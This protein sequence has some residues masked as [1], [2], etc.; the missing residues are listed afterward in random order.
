MTTPD[1][2]HEKTLLKKILASLR[3]ARGPDARGE[4]VCWCP[5]HPDGKGKPPHQPNLFVSERGFYCHACGAKGSLV[6]LAEKLGVQTKAAGNDPEAIYDYCDENGTL[7]FQVIRFRGKRFRQRRPDGKDGWIWDLK[8]V[9][10]V[11][12]R[13]PELFT[14]PPDETVYIVEGEKDCDRLAA[15]GLI[16]TTNPGGAGKWRREYSEPSRGRAVAILSDNDEPGRGHVQSVAHMLHG[17]AKSIK[18]IDLPG[19]PEKGDVSDWLA[20][21][22]TIEELKHL[23]DAA[24]NWGPTSSQVSAPIAIER[25]GS[26]KSSWPD[27][28]A[29]AAFHGLAGDFVRAIEPHT[30]ADPVALLLSFLVALGNVVERAAH[31]IADGAKHYTNLFCVLVGTTSKSRKGTSWAQTLRPFQVVDEEWARDRVQHGLSSGEGLIWGVRDQIERLEPIRDKKRIVD[32]QTVIE[33]QGVEDKRLLVA[34]TEFAMT[35]RVMG[36]DGNTL[37]AIVRNA[38]DTGNLRVLT[39]NQ[40]A[41]STGAHVSIIGHI[42]K[43][44]C[45]RYFDRTEVANG[46]GNRFI[47]ACV[48]RSKLLPEGGRIH[49]VDFGPLVQRLSAAKE[50]ACATSEMTRDETARSLWYGVYPVLAEGQPGLLGAILA[51]AEAQVMRLACVYALLDLSQTVRCEHL[52]AALAVWKYCEDSARFIFGDALGDPLADEILRILRGMEGGMTR[53]EISNCFGRNREAREITRALERL[54]EHGLARCE[55]EGGA[56]GRPIERWFPANGARFKTSEG[57]K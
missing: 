48:R 38:W 39:K 17:A 57:T 12:Y 51:R 3:I 55:K 34:E 40:P 16:A 5:F 43:D 36:R 7:L 14:A 6:Q 35:L 42:T 50:F 52:E 30:E 27:P 4:Y 28:P 44:E 49:E 18:L 19:L 26:A 29:D 25:T 11:P 1:I 33:D 47:W 15:A 13:L 24:P 23:I 37:S 22:H 53:T 21:G 46:F 54:I 32:Y 31:F 9:R 10:R 56:P 20:T 2:S 45:L 8:S 41:K